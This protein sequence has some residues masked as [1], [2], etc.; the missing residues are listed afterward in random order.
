MDVL[1]YNTAKLA[2]GAI[3]PLFQTKGLFKGERLDG[4]IIQLFFFLSKRF[5]DAGKPL[6]GTRDEV[7]GEKCQK[8]CEPPGVVHIIKAEEF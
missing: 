4:V 6:K 8:G 3:I 7:K 1:L 2:P 5:P